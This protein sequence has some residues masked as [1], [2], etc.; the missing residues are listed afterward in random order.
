M[1][2]GILKKSFLSGE[3]R[4][5]KCLLKAS[6]MKRTVDIKEVNQIHY[7][8]GRHLRLESSAYPINRNRSY[9]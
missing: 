9:F 3:Y 1:Q 8:Q 4:D 5:E 6:M 7:R 2:S